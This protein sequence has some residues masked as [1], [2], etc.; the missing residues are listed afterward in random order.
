MYIRT[1][2]PDLPSE[3]KPQRPVGSFMKHV[4]VRNLGVLGRLIQEALREHVRVV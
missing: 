3:K 2:F 1:T 4:R